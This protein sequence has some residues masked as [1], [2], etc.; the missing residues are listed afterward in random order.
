MTVGYCAGAM[1]EVAVVGAGVMGLSAAVAIQERMPS[2]QVTVVADKLSVDT[3][4]DGAGGL[5][6]PYAAGVDTSLIR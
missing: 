1:P 6:V 5:F 2:V 3:T 4:S